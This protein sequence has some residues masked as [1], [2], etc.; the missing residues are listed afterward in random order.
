MKND[1]NYQNWISVAKG[2]G[3]MLVVFGHIYIGPDSSYVVKRWIYSFHMPLF[4]FISGLLRKTTVSA[5]PVYFKKK[6]K[7][8]VIPYFIYGIISIIYF[9]IHNHDK[10]NID[11]VILLLGKLILCQGSDRFLTFNPA[12]WFLTCLF[13]VEIIAYFTL[14]RSKTIIIL[15]GSLSGILGIILSTFVGKIDIFWNID[16]SLIAFFYYACGFIYKS[17]IKFRKKTKQESIFIVTVFMISIILLSPSNG[18]FSLAYNKMGNSN[19]LGIILSFLG[20]Y[21]IIELAQIINKNKIFEYLGNHTLT[22]MSLHWIGILNISRI[23]KYFDLRIEL[24]NQLFLSFF[25]SF[26]IILLIL[27]IDKIYHIAKMKSFPR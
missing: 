21:L 27:V 9:G 2:L 22:I 18:I 13:I 7:N 15:I 12:L 19:L 26:I 5:F 10:V 17:M 3:I 24:Q 6:I 4:F 25:Y 14:S 23:N 1:V 20:I 8:L 16:I 11:F